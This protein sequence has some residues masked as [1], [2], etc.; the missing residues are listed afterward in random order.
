[1]TGSTSDAG[2]ATRPSAA[3]MKVTEWASVKVVAASHDLAQTARPGDER[4]QEQD[5]VDPAEQMLGAEAEELPV[6]A[7]ASDCWVENVG[8]FA[9]R[10]ALPDFRSRS[11]VTIVLVSRT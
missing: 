10:A 4:Q 7:G 3:R 1:M 11:Y 5:V 6:L 9:S 8:C 2:T